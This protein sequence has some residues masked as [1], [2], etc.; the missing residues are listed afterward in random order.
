MPE[1][2]LGSRA[3]LD[4]LTRTR[5]SLH[6]VAEHVLAAALYAATGDF[7][8]RCG[9]GGFRTPPFGDRTM[10]AVEGVDLVMT[11]AAAQRRQR[12][13][14]VRAAAEFVGIE[15]GFPERVYRAATTLRP[16]APLE[17]DAEAARVLASW[18]AL[19]DEA[20]A[21]LA[22]AHPDDRPSAA[23]LFPEHFDLGIAAAGVNYGASPGDDLV[24]EP[25][26][27]VGPH[28]G[29][30]AGDPFWNAPFGAYRTA[31]QVGS[32]QD[33]AAFFETGRR[34]ARTAAAER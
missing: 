2:V 8:L 29:P 16:D 28:G 15:P 13:A 19:G 11:T 4:A 23:L 6:Q 7:V 30:P 3:S 20:L 27:Y 31:R 10:L 33:A 14:T 34:R 21:V 12:L 18:Y 22:A 26:V 1:L 24:P 17:V 5:Q 25:Y 9:P 32:A